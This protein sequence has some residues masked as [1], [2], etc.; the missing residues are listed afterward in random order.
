MAGNDSVSASSTQRFY[1]RA[2][3]LFWEQLL[4]EWHDWYFWVYED[5]PLIITTI[6]QLLNLFVAF[7][8][9]AVVAYTFQ[10][11]RLPFDIILSEEELPKLSFR[12]SFVRR[13]PPKPS[14][15]PTVVPETPPGE[16][17]Q[18]NGFEKLKVGFG[19]VE[20]ID[21]KKSSCVPNQKTVENFCYSGMRRR[22]S[23]LSRKP[24]P[25]FAVNTTADEKEENIEISHEI[26]KRHSKTTHKTKSTKGHGSHKKNTR[27]ANIRPNVTSQSVGSNNTMISQEPIMKD[28]LDQ[29][30][31]QDF[32]DCKAQSAI[33]LSDS[34][35]DNDG[36][37]PILL[38]TLPRS[39]SKYFKTKGNRIRFDINA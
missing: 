34:E 38:K 21:E 23:T 12:F 5:F 6:A 13:R 36:A 3:S 7:M 39:Q 31:H 32:S 24:K 4:L 26:F 30:Y 10:I 27:F 16:Q 19:D 1:V 35:S 29:V 2:R 20:I 22:S 15:A 14:L 37:R 25:S 18:P 17:V 11:L 9:M 28:D 33:Q 8:T